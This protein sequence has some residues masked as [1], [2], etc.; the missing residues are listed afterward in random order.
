MIP[1]F[2]RV[3]VRVPLPRG[4][5]CCLLLHRAV[6]CYMLCGAQALI[7]DRHTYKDAFEIIGCEASHVV[8]FSAGDKNRTSHARCSSLLG[9]EQAGKYSVRDYSIQL[10]SDVGLPGVLWCM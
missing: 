6:G 3:R 5:D 1:D 4:V 2:R 8:L 10:H 7:N 9:K